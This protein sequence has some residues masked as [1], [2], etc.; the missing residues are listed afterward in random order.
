VDT[1]SEADNSFLNGGRDHNFE[2]EGLKRKLRE[3]QACK[4]EIESDI[5]TIERALGIM[6][7]V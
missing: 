1:E 2:E 4:L 6:I 3:L 5:A 7:N